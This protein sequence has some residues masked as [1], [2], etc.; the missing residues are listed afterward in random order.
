MKWRVRTGL[1]QLLGVLL[2]GVL[3]ALRVWDPAVV[4]TVRNQSF[5]LLQRTWP[6]I[7]QP[8]PVAIVDIDERSLEAVGQ[9]PWPRTRL[10]A[11][12]ESV[13]AAGSPAMAFDMVFAEPDRLSPA[14]VA[15]AL[16]SLPPDVRAAL[17]AMPPTVA[18]FAEAMRNFRV[19]LGQTSVRSERDN[20][21]AKREML[22]APVAFIGP[23]PTP[24]MSAFPDIVQNRPELRE[25]AAGRGMFNV[26]PDADGIFRR[27][28]LVMTVQ[29]KVRLALSAELLRIATGGNAF[30]V[31]GDELGI[32]GIV[33]A[34]KLVPTDRNG[35]VWPH[36]TGHEPARFVSAADVLAG[37][38]SDRLRG[39]LVLVGTSAVGLEDYRATPMGVAMAG[40]EIHA[41]VLENILADAM[42]TRPHYAIGAELAVAFLFGTF[43]IL[44]VPRVG[45]RPSIAITGVLL[46][47]WLAASLVLFRTEKLLL[48]PSFPFLATTAVLI[49]TATGNY[50]RE[51][52]ERKAIRSAFGQYVSPD[53]VDQLADE[54]ERLGLGGETRELSVLFSD[55]R[56]FTALS[57]SFK[58]DPQGLTKLMNQLLNGMSEAI[59]ENGGTIDKFMGDAVMAFWNAPLDTPDHARLS[60]KA[61]LAMLASVERLNGERADA[62]H[63]PVRLLDIG[64]GINTGTCIVGNMG[65]DRRFDYTALGDTVNIASRLEGQS[66][67]YGVKIILGDATAAAVPDMAV[68]ELDLIR[69][70][71]REAPERIFALL[72]DAAFAN[73]KRFQE[74]RDLNDAMISTYRGRDFADALDILDQMNE[75]AADLLLDLDE[76]LLLYRGRIEEFMANPPGTAWNGVYTA[77]TK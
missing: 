42:L 10:A 66:K 58:S 70:K 1:T 43:V 51:E 36:F 19:V 59:L 72:G 46:A 6:R 26:Y 14:N 13:R 8:A 69:V 7:Y 47:G 16:P 12:V 41:Q 18:S 65:S 3:L 35:T 22:D 57:E 33:V 55:V 38:A 68:L 56:G 30:G 77:T 60:A 9:W 76:Y 44:A 25:A 28:P 49:L 61:A 39:R 24:H 5:D 62:A 52:N 75:L 32:F 54:P 34:G 31:K 21:D 45:A 15:A 73:D 50:L 64:C 11:L 48:D 2:L 20:R 17:E 37:T 67:T 27:V 63:G 71:G 23:D 4:Q 74:L 29:G 53:L 40:V